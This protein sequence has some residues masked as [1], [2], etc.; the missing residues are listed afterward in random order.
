MLIYISGGTRSGKSSYAQK[1]ALSLSDNPVYLATARVWDNEFEA[2]IK[3][4]QQDRDYR[5]ENIQ[6]EKYPGRLNLQ[7]RVVVL[8]CVTLWITNFFTDTK[9]DER[10]TLSAIKNAF[11]ELILIETTWIIISNELGMGLHADSENGRKFADLQGWINQYI[12]NKA[13]KAIFMV[14]GIPLI[15][16][17]GE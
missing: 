16:K 11:D 14:S 17:D 15:V 10:Q 9:Y 7:N 8:D 4:H 5:W 3:R 13:D 6:E 2:R 1:L 12:A